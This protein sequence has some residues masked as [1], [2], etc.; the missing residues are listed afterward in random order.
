MRESFARWIMAMQ[1]RKRRKVAASLK[2]EG[3]KLRQS[4][5]TTTAA[6]KRELGLA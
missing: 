1:A 5:A 3:R 4:K 6:L 2:N